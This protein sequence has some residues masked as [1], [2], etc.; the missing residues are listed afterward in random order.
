MMVEFTG[1]V[2]EVGTDFEHVEKTGYV[3]ISLDGGLGDVRLLLST[4]DAKDLAGALYETV[5][6]TIAGGE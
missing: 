6:T 2:I 5:S 4:D 1:E 3:V